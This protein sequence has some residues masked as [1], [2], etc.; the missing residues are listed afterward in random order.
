MSVKVVYV[1]GVVYAATRECAVWVG[2]EESG[3]GFAPFGSVAASGCAGPVV[4]AVFWA[5][6]FIG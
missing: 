6:G 5:A 4:F 3:T 1:G 2:F